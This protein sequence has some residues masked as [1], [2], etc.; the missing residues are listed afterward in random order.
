MTLAS[1]PALAVQTPEH[2]VGYE[3]LIFEDVV[4]Q[5]IDPRNV[6]GCSTSRG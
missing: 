5:P 1:L 4:T 6:L 3:G 2:L